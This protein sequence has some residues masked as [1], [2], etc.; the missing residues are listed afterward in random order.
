MPVW[1]QAPWSVCLVYM[2][3]DV[4]LRTVSLQVAAEMGRISAG[5]VHAD[6]EGAASVLWES[7]RATLPPTRA[8]A[9]AH[10]HAK[11]T[12]AEPEGN[13]GNLKK[14]KIKGRVL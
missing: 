10:L 14:K 4:H 13:L 12:P 3:A 5:N 6:D 11:L 1:V 9:W 7:V 8:D 2:W